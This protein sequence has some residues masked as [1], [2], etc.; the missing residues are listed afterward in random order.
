[1]YICYQIVSSLAFLLVFPFFLLF[2]LVTGKHRNRLEQRLGIYPKQLKKQPGVLRIWLH[3]SSVGEVQAARAIIPKIR[4]LL[5][6]A[7]FL[8]STMTAHGRQQ[9]KKCLDADVICVLAPL[10]V[11]FI[12]GRAFHIIDPDLYVCIETEIWPLI[13]KTISDNG[14]SLVLANGRM[15]ESSHKGY[16]K[17]RSFMGQILSLFEHAALIS[18]KDYDRYVSLG[19]DGNN[20]QVLGNVKYDLSLPQ[21]CET[22]R[23]HYR[24]ILG[25][26]EESEI[27]VA[28]STHGNEEEQL[29]PLISPEC[30]K[31]K[32]L[33]LIAP[34]HLERV[35]QL[36]K[37]LD[38]KR[39]PYDL[40]ST[41]KTGRSRNHNLI[42]V[43]CMGE[44]ASLYSVADYVFCG[45]SLVPRGGHNVMEAALWSKPVFYGP[46]M[47][48]FKDAARMLEDAEAGFEI[49][50]VQDLIK[51]LNYYRDH[52]QEYRLAC[53]NAG[54]LA[55]SQQGSAKKQAEM[56]VSLLK[57]KENI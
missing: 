22:V 26:D 31:N 57:K 49:S 24:L 35:P 14:R 52:N 11:P 39:Q 53:S 9:A 13:L 44:L 56:M 20:S 19:L 6:D 45:G 10:D 2:S 16:L 17:I 5:P 30:G 55:K 32:R 29:L 15:S 43:D 21:N 36:R 51:K 28:G 18:V 48:D 42:L 46:H 7:E 34:R 25:L 41:L 38:S 23:Q 40:L 33:L 3:A 50:G 4:K 12:V 8:V 27:V 47:A 54:K 37:M 1:M